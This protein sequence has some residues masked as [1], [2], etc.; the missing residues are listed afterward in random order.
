MPA[1]RLL[2]VALTAFMA[3]AS[4]H[5]DEAR[6][7]TAKDFIETLSKPAPAQDQITG[8][9]GKGAKPRFRLR[10]ITTEARPP[11]IAIHILFKS[12]SI[13]VADEFSKKQMAEAGKAISSEILNPYRFEIAGHTDSVGSDEYNQ[14]LSERRAQA[15]KQ[16]LIDHY[17]VAEDRLET[18][19][20]GESMPVADN[21]TEQGRAKNR[22]V[23]FKR[24]F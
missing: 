9:V 7:V 21:A 11:E 12:G 23:V 16:F 18:I 24:L 13:A 6:L 5:A 3:A 15:L 1:T 8:P 17:K 14:D 2:L 19:G 22:R 20:Y 10:G 4:S